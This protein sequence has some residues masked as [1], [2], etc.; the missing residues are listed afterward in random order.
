MATKATKK[1]V[2]ATK[3][4]KATKSVKA[5]VYKSTGAHYL[6]L[7]G[8]VILLIGFWTALFAHAAALGI[9]L[10]LIGILVSVVGLSKHSMHILKRKAAKA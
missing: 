4:V 8:V 2:R 6:I 9:I 3:R 1:R 10:L 5:N 7:V